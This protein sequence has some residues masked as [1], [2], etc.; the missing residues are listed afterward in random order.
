MVQ[1]LDSAGIGQVGLQH[2]VRAR[3]FPVWSGGEAKSIGKHRREK[4]V[5]GT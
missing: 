1:E 4:I 2:L 3:E 5:E